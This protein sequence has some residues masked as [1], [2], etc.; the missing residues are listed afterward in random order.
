MSGE[1]FYISS[2]LLIKTLG[3]NSIQFC[4]IPINHYLFTSQSKDTILYWHC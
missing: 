4:Q 1:T 3:L 2:Y